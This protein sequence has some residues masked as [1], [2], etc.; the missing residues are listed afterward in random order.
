MNNRPCYDMLASAVP[1][2]VPGNRWTYLVALTSRA[3]M[4]R[5]DNRKSR[6][7]GASDILLQP[8][9]RR[10][11]WATS[12]SQGIRVYPPS[13]R[14][15]M[16]LSMPEILHRPKCRTQLQVGLGSYRYAMAARVQISVRPPKPEDP[17]L[18]RLAAG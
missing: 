7:P 2:P 11:A 13:M 6:T 17:P 9:T 1:C 14:A 15:S 12:T 16:Q 4:G 8:T 5:A 3:E 18:Q 10:T